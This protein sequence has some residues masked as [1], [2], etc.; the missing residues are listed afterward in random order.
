MQLGRGR[1]TP[2]GRGASVGHG[3]RRLQEVVS[4]FRVPS[5]DGVGSLVGAV[6]GREVNVENGGTT[7]S[8]ADALQQ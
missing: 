2:R 6:G 3:D 5:L 7:Y 8:S 4:V 1:G